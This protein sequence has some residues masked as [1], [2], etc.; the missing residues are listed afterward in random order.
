MRSCLT[1]SFLLM[2]KDLFDTSGEEVGDWFETSVDE[3]QEDVEQMLTDAT[4]TT[5]TEARREVPVDTGA[6]K[7]DIT[8]DEHEVYNT[9][10]YA[11][12]VGLG[13]V[14]MDKQDYLWGPAAEAIKKALKTLENKE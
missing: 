1:Y 9:L 6:L 13:T 3:L 7:D 5:Y 4:D 11:P 8:K 12:H 2:A 14:F 10:H